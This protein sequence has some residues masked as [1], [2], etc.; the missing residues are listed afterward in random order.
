MA[1]WMAEFSKPMSATGWPAL[2][3]FQRTQ[4]RDAETAER[5]NRERKARYG[6]PK[7][8]TM[9]AERKPV[10]VSP[11]LVAFSEDFVPVKPE[12]E[13]A[14]RWGAMCA[15]HGYP[16][17]TMGANMLQLPAGEPEEAMAEF[18]R[19]LSEGK[20]DDDAA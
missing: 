20:G 8:A 19:R 16:W 18:Q 15:R 12:S 10:T 17:S 13:L 2:T 1:A 9:M 4:M 3:A 5:I 11:V 6:W 14:A 7:A